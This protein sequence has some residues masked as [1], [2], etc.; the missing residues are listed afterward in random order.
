M[1]LIK[2]PAGRSWISVH[3]GSAQHGGGHGGGGCGHDQHGHGHGHGHGSF[4]AL[5]TWIQEVPALS[6]CCPAGIWSLCAG[7]R[8]GVTAAQRD[9]NLGYQSFG[10]CSARLVLGGFA[11][12]PT[13]PARASA[14]HPSAPHPA[15]APP[16][17]GTQGPSPPRAHPQG[18]G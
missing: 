11:Q 16:H 2:F 1:G 12:A 13:S 15:R 7:T 9:L 6:C 14:L 10:C 4:C 17:S 18:P 8:G 5:L 3:L